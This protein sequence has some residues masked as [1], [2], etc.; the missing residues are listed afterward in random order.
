MQEL[1][2]PS[3]VVFKV[4]AQRRF[5]QSIEDWL[6]EGVGYDGSMNDREY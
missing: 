5:K 2:Q 4:H 1:K 6:N 3:G